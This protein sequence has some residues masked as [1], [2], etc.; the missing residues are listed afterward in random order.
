MN[1]FDFG[2]ALIC[3]G[4]L[5]YGCRRGLVTVAGEVLGALTGA[6]LAFGLRRAWSETAL[7]AAWGGAALV[8]LAGIYAGIMGGLWVAAAWRRRQHRAWVRLGDALAGGLFGAGLALV[9]GFWLV[10][11]LWGL[12][13]EGLAALMEGSTFAH[14]ALDAWW[15]WR[16]AFAN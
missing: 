9:L 16:L 7:G 8:S 1:G 4:S 11:W 14:W 10:V 5:V 2:V 12:P 15:T 6:G 3:G 13:S